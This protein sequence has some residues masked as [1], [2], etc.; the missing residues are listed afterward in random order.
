MGGVVRRS[1]VAPFAHDRVA[2]VD[3]AIAQQLYGMNCVLEAGRPLDVVD[4]HN[5]DV[6]RRR[7]PGIRAEELGVHSWRDDGGNRH[8]WETA[9]GCPDLDGMVRKHHGVG[10]LAQPEVAIR[11]LT[12]ADV[13]VV[14]S[15]CHGQPRS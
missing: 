4:A 9:L 13:H 12:G 3:A 6:G 1:A 11:M 14:G 2:T 5:V 8:R 7:P 15:E 10:V